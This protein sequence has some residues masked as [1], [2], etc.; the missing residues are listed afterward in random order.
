M[1]FIIILDHA[2]VSDNNCRRGVAYW[3]CYVFITL[4]E[5]LPHPMQV[6][7]QPVLQWQRLYPTK[8]AYF[9]Y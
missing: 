2:K 1:I 8:L 4:L 6:L 3:Y 5:A 7:F 9:P